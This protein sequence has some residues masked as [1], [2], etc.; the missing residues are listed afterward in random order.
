MWMLTVF[1]Q[2]ARCQAFFGMMAITQLS[3]SLSRGRFSSSRPSRGLDFSGAKTRAHGERRQPEALVSETYPDEAMPLWG[4]CKQA[5][6]SRQSANFGSLKLLAGSHF[7]A[8]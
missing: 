2:R 8:Y 7:H 1:L 5:I 3:P 4:R 6:T